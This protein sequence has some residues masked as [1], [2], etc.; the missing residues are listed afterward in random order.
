MVKIKESQGIDIW[1]AG[2][3]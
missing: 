3:F 1:T 2:P